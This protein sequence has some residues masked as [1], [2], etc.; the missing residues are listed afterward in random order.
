MVWLPIWKSSLS[1]PDVVQKWRA[2]GT[3]EGQRRLHNHTITDSADFAA[4]LT[5]L[6]AGESA[7]ELARCVPRDGLRFGGANFGN[8]RPDFC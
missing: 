3:F 7:E 4:L 6:P 2:C 1:C 8:P 5:E